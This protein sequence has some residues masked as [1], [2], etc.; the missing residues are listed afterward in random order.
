V[1]NF[2]TAI[3]LALALVNE[4]GQAEAAIK[5]GQPATIGDP[6]SGGAVKTY[7]FGKHVAIG[8]IPINPA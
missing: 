5:A 3:A 2:F 7:L 4:L 8:P 1:N 6:A